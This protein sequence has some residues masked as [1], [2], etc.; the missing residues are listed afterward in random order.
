MKTKLQLIPSFFCW[1]LFG[2]TAMAQTPKLYITLISHNEDN[3]GY[4]NS[5]TLYYNNR[6]KLVTI[7][8][9]LQTKGAKYNYGGDWVALEAIADLDTG[10]VLSSTNGKNI[11]RWMVEDKG[12][13]CD[14]HSHESTRNYADVHYLMSQLGI[15]PTNTMSGYLYDTLQGGHA[16]EDYQNGV[17]GIYFPSHTWQPQVLWGAATPQHTH[18]PHFFGA[19]KPGGLDSFFEHTPSNNLTAI[20]TGC[21]IKLEST[22]TIGAI[23][24]LIDNIVADIQSGNLPSNGFYTQEIFFSEGKV[25]QSWFMTLFNKVI[26][27]VNVHVGNGT[28]EW[29]SLSEIH[30]LWQTTYNSEPFAYDCAGNNSLVTGVEDVNTENSHILLYPNPAN[31]YLTVSSINSEETKIIVY[32]S[33]GQALITDTFI[34]TGSI[35]LNGLN[36]GMYIVQFTQKNRSIAR[37]LLKQS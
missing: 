18:D 12:F 20:G 35:S 32:N 37:K 36:N 25:N 17:T 6:N 34:G 7:C 23:D 1:L 31:D 13:E 2:S 19:F 27:S 4:N 26:D 28:V 22:T 10:S 11:L 30:N 8:N 5:S 16:W 15:T 14:P 21:Q 33:L 9:T 3:I 29:K 24:S